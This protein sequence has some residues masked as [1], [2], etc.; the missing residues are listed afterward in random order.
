MCFDLFADVG[1][2]LV[3]PVSKRPAHQ[4]DK[5]SESSAYNKVLCK[6]VEFHIST[7]SVQ[8][9]VVIVSGEVGLSTYLT[10]ERLTVAHLLQVVKTAGD[11]LVAV[12]VEGI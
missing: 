4:A 10:A 9:L 5:C 11:A 6:F 8:E 7:S 3:N 2:Q 1:N 12:A